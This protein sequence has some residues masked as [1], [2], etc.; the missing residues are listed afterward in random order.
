MRSTGDEY[1]PSCIL[2]KQAYYLEQL[3]TTE[4]DR[5]RRYPPTTPGLAAAMERHIAAY[6]EEIAAA[7]ALAEAARQGADDYHLA[8]AK[9]RLRAAKAAFDAAEKHF[10]TICR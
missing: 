6:R 1:E 10:R 4:A 5:T 3:V 9:A 7:R 2:L 8:V